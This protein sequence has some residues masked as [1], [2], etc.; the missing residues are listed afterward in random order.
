[1]QKKKNMLFSIDFPFLICILATV[2]W[3][4]YLDHRLE[5]CIPFIPV[6]RDA[7]VRHNRLVT[8]SLCLTQLGPDDDNPV[9]LDL[10][11]H[12]VEKF[13]FF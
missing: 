2:D 1:M 5:F 12:F 13:F 6:L 11:G 7:K 9:G 8:S 3:G 10:S 4:T